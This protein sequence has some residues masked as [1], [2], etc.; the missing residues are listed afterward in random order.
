MDNDQAKKYDVV[1]VG[2][3][4]GGL[5]CGLILAM[6]GKSVC[7][8]EKN[9]Q[10]GGSLQTFKRDGVKFDT[11]VHYVGALDKG[12]PLH[13]Y[14]KYLGI[15]DGLTLEKMDVDGHDNVSFGNEGVLYPHAQS[16]ENFVSQLLKHFPQEK[17]GLNKYI[18]A[19]TETCDAFSL[20]NLS[21]EENFQN[22]IGL[23]DKSAKEVINSCT[24]NKKLR[25]VLAGVNMLYAGNGDKAP[26]YIHALIVNHYM[27]SAYRFPNGGDQI[28]KL[29]E[30]RIRN[31][32]G[33][34]F[35]N[36]EVSSLLLK[37]GLISKARLK[38]GI[39]IGAD[40][41]IS[42][43]HPQETL[44]IIKG[45]GLRKSF[46]N[47]VMNLKN[48]S[49]SFILYVVLKEKTLP[50]K[51]HNVYHFNSPDV[52]D[53]D[54]NTGEKWGRDFGVFYSRS[55]KHPDY[56]ESISIITYMKFDE[57][58]PWAKTVNLRHQEENRG[59]SYGEFK[60]EKSSILL[61][62]AS[63]LIPDFRNYIHS[64]Y[65]STPLTYRDYLNVSD[66]SIY[67]IERDFNNPLNTY[68]NTKTRVKNL[69]LTGQNLIMH[70]ILGV[71]IGAVVTCSK[72]LGG[73][74]LIKKIKAKS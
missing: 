70:G 3:G 12:Q 42:S 17:E 48:T 44:K 30:K 21:E 23:F 73:A 2:S 65:S 4:M 10:I 38:D 56:C 19:I 69:Y 59:K 45:R 72:I 64:Y 25:N 31:L 66:G 61:N 71:T 11:G 60:E 55:K 7:I 51:N 24:K 33:K 67:G 37:D 27:L 41:F 5:T 47:R 26:F 16:P 54:N 28:A 20:Y 57:V 1:I 40:V 52:W 15:M 74:Y 68:I 14:F 49:A 50:Y 22:E 34:V 58:E 46:V 32:G 53:S 63:V 39:E 35:R 6:E 29:L 8:L 9:P 43:M 62:Y 13:R 36:A 18:K